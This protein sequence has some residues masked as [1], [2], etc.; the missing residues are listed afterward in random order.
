MFGVS[1]HSPF[2]LFY[3]AVVISALMLGRSAGL[4]TTVLA[5]AMGLVFV[6]PV[7]SL[8]IP[9]LEETVGISLFIAVSVF[10]CSVVDRLCTVNSEVATACAVAEQ[11]RAAAEAAWQAEAWAR[12]RAEAG[13]QERKLLL[14]EFTHRFKN[15]LARLS[16]A[17][18]LQARNAPAEVARALQGAANRVQGIAKVHEHLSPRQGHVLIDTRGFLEEL[19][20]SFAMEYLDARQIHIAVD[21]EQ[22]LIP[23]ARASTLGLIVNELLTNALKHA[24]PDERPGEVLIRFRREASWFYLAVADDG[25]GMPEASET[26]LLGEPTVAR[27]IGQTLVRALVAQLDGT[28]SVLPLSGSGTSIV[29]EIP[30][31]AIQ[32]AVSAA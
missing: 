12:N 26:K 24:F 18:A 32:S 7:G 17:L 21:A 8:A 11:S 14:E 31:W 28:V 6:E 30:A 29:V 27:G 5:A 23:V 15:D 10:I 9:D 16:A 20:A 3:P 2:T 19:G 22:H 4:L 13:E 25:V 1:P